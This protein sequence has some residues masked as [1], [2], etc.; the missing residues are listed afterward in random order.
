MYKISLSEGRNIRFCGRFAFEW[1]PEFMVPTRWRPSAQ[2]IMCPTMS[3]GC[4]PATNHRVWLLRRMVLTFTWPDTIG[5]FSVGIHKAESICNT[6]TIIAE[7]SKPYY[8][9]LC[10]RVTCHSAQCASKNSV[11]CP[12]TYCCWRT[13][14]W[15]WQID[16]S[17]FRQEQFCSMRRKKCAF[18]AFHLCNFLC[19]KFSLVVNQWCW[20]ILSL[21]LYQYLA[22]FLRL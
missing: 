1:H 7:T 12:D 18:C 19:A 10:Q 4:I 17:H 16:K 2:G 13:S 5:L 6:S 20:I 8:G 22:P 15:A 11:P 21:T 3:S 9:C 14:F